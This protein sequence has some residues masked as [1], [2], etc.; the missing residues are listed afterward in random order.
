MLRYLYFS[1]LSVSIL[2]SS[3]FDVNG[4]SVYDSDP[5]INLLYPT[6]GEVLTGNVTVRWYTDASYSSY[7]VYIYVAP[8]NSYS[9]IEVARDLPNTGSFVWDTSNYTDGH[10]RLLVEI[11]VEN[12][13]AHD[14][15]DEFI[16]DNDNSDL[17]IVDV[18]VSTNSGYPAIKNG[19]TVEIVAIIAHGE[20]LNRLDIMANLTCLGKVGTT[21]AEFFDGHSARW[22][23]HDVYCDISDGK[24]YI[25]IDAYGIE[26]YKVEV[27]LDNTPPSLEIVYPTNGVY[28][29][30]KF[31]FP[32]D[33]IYLLF[34]FTVEGNVSDST[35]ISSVEIFI[36]NVL[37]ASIST[38][39]SF[40][41]ECSSS[42][43]GYHTV[44][45]KVID[46]AGHETKE[47]L[48]AHVFK[49]FTS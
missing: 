12:Y 16:I 35:D 47:T 8:E 44:T 26:E 19:D 49:F 10:Y 40:R 6:G 5:S 1:L 33:S 42:I 2:L 22:E 14:S 39:L 3:T 38:S 17:K 36:D 46:T 43:V 15:S 48:G 29:L 18:S 13:I 27:T 11:N 7:L 9:W 37:E 24:R 21:P 4:I 31:I 20:Y 28:F 30:N 25:A 32:S 23:I 34:S 45:V 41:W